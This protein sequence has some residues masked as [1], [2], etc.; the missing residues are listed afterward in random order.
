MLNVQWSCSICPGR[1]PE[2]ERGYS[3]TIRWFTRMFL[4]I[5]LL[6]DVR[7]DEGTDHPLFCLPVS[8]SPLDPSHWPETHRRYPRPRLPRVMQLTLLCYTL[9]PP[10]SLSPSPPP[11]GNKQRPWATSLFLWVPSNQVSEPNRTTMYIVNCN[12]LYLVKFT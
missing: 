2:K 1:L 12:F 11:S 9:P 8:V 10:S 5:R 4:S 6:Q 7:M 3:S